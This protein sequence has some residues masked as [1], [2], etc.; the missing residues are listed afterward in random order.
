MLERL[1]GP[2][3]AAELFAHLHIVD[4]ARER[5]FA[6]ADRVGRAR[7]PG[8]APPMVVEPCRIFR[9]DPG[10]LVDPPAVA[11]DRAGS[12]RP[13]GP[14]GPPHPHPRSLGRTRTPTRAPPPPA[15]PRLVEP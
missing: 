1:K 8:D 3:H 9:Q 6:A 14:L 15:A 4:R 5:G 12:A 13:L 7:D 2:D 11:G 10:I